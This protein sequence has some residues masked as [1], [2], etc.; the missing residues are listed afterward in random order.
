MGLTSAGSFMR[1][2]DTFPFNQHVSAPAHA[3]RHSGPCFYFGSECCDSVF[4]HDIFTSDHRCVIFIYLYLSYTSNFIWVGELIGI[5][6]PFLLSGHVTY[7]SRSKTSH[8]ASPQ[9]AHCFMASGEV[10]A[11]KMVSSTHF[12]KRTIWI[13]LWLAVIDPPPSFHLP[14]RS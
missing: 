5:E 7:N 14:L 9:C 8:S 1:V 11:S 13:L 2:M 10:A 12:W 4:S 3:K 6:S